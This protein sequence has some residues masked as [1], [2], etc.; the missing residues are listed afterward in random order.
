[1]EDYLPGITASTRQLEQVWKCPERTR[2]RFYQAWI[3]VI[4]LLRACQPLGE[5]GL[6]PDDLTRH[7]LEGDRLIMSDRL[8]Y[9][10]GRALW[11][12]NHGQFGPANSRDTLTSYADA[13]DPEVTGMHQAYGDGHVEWKRAIAHGA[14]NTAGDLVG[15]I[16]AVP[17]NPNRSYYFR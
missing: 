1:M 6:L 11:R 17:S 8:Y 16:E 15:Y 14:M 3:E 7:Q 13:G 5:P 10:D 12:Y 9:S 2:D 4:Q